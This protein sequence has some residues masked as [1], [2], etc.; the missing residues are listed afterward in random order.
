MIKFKCSTCKNEIG[1]V[2]QGAEISCAK[3]TIRAIPIGSGS[4]LF[5]KWICRNCDKDRVDLYILQNKIAL[6][7]WMTGGQNTTDL[8]KFADYELKY[9]L[10]RRERER[11]KLKK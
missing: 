3:F 10:E 2:E 1:V 5:E 9:E 11:G 8:S 7:P 4:A 6:R